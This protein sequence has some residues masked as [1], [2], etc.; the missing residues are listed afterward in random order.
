MV[1]EEIQKTAFRT[2]EGH[3][4][5]LVMPFGLT[6]ASAT[7][8]ALMNTIFKPYLR[9]FVLVFFD[10]ILISSKDEKEHVH[11]MEKLKIEYL[12]HILSRDGVAIDPDKIKAIVDWPCPM[13]VREVR[14]LTGYYRRF[15]QHYGSI[16]AP[17]THLLK[18]G[19]FKWNDEAKE[20]FEKLKKAMMSLPV[21]A[22]PSFDH[23]FE[24]E[25]DASGYGVGAVLIQSKRSI[26][27]YS[28]T[29]A[30]RVRARPVYERELMAVVLAVQHWRPY[31]LGTRFI[32]KTDQKSLKFLLEQRVVQPQYQKWVA[33][34][35]GYSFEVV[36]KPGLKNKAADAL[37][38]KPPDIQFCGITAPV[39]VDLK[40]IREEVEKDE[41]L[42][43]V[44]AELSNERELKDVVG[45]HSRFLRTYKRVASKLYWEG[46]KFDVKRHCEE[47]LTCQRNK[48]LAVSPAGLLVPLEILQVWSDISMDFVEGLPK[49][50]GFE[51]VLVVVDRLSNEKPKEWISWLPWAKFWY[52]TTFQRALSGSPFQVVYGPLRGH[53]LLAQQQMKQ[54]ADRKRRHV[55]FQ[56]VDLV[57]LK[58]RPYRQLTLRRK[59][60]E[61]LSPKYFGP[62]KILEK[63]GVVAYK[64][65]LPANTAIHP[66]FHVS[67]LKKCVG[68]QTGVLPTIQ[69]VNEKFEWQT[70]PEEVLEYKLN[71]AGSWDVL[72][73]WKGLPKHEASWES[74][75]EM[76]KLY[77]NLHLEDKVNLEGGSNVRPPTK[78]V[79]KRKNKEHV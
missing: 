37:S 23:P 38:R 62:Y 61:K 44:V 25:T 2:H 7:F 12:G 71:K 18:K 65:D 14:G 29:L 59:R 72:I 5:F 20:A 33:K 21:L 39:L 42:W 24:I 30:M 43:K 76:H 48:I 45:G 60:N 28:H 41:Q 66:V 35:L 51:V 13:N 77:P 27:F 50:K 36:Y 74:Y 53:L 70:Q 10:D 47:C 58:I 15:V 19:G 40:I 78:F 4:E 32:V 56:V 3:Y 34:L 9:K 57:F 1:D 31:L 79:Y 16:A 8:Q 11:H 17:L 63:I 49:A 46:M 6:N 55:K 52:N 75:D 64:L 26:A 68:D 54:Y 22:L 67:Q 69:Y 73:G